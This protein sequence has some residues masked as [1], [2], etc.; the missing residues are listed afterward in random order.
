MGAIVQMRWDLII[1][2]PECTAMALSGN[3][4]YAA[5]MPKH[6]KRQEAV[7]WTLKLWEHAKKN[8]RM[9]ALENPASVIFPYLR[10]TGATTQFIHPHHFGHPEFKATGFA[11][12][13][14][15]ELIP[16]DPLVVPEKGTE[17]Y[18]QWEKVFRMAPG[19]DRATNRSRTYLGIAD[20]ISEQWGGE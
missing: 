2:H 15:P 13:G 19:P 17:M 3:K 5:G 10:K 20:A 12:H 16:T 11:L 9:V 14:L 7:D 18:K 1:L 4:H 8:A 6:H